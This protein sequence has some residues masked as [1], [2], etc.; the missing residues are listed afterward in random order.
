MAH[1]ISKRLR[2]M[3][4]T[5]VAL[6]AALLLVPATAFAWDGGSD[7]GT[8]TINGVQPGD[9]VHLYTI[10]T[11]ELDGQ[12]QA[13]MQAVDP[14]TQEHVNAYTAT[15]AG[16]AGAV[17]ALAGDFNADTAHE[18]TSAEVQNGQTSVSMTVDPGLYLVKVTP[19]DPDV[20]YQTTI[21]AVNV[22]GHETSWTVSDCTL[23]LKKTD[24]TLNKTVVTKNT[25]GEFTSESDNGTAKVGDTLTFRIYFTVGT[26]QSSLVLSDSMTAGL[27]FNND[28]RLYNATTGQEVASTTSVYTEG[29]APEGAIDGFTLTF[30]KDWLTA[31]SGD[32]VYTNAGAYYIEYTAD[33]TDDFTTTGAT[34]TVSN[35]Q[36]QDESN[37]S[38]NTFSVVKYAENGE[39]EGKQDDEST[40]QGAK[41]TLCSDAAGEN[42]VK[43]KYGTDI[44]FTVGPDGSWTLTNGMTNLGFG[45]YY[46]REDAAPSG[47]DAMKTPMKIEWNAD[48]QTFYVPNTASGTDS[49]IGLPTT[50]G[51]GT[52]LFTA[53]GVVIIAGAAAFIVRSRKQND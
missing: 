31:T 45:T 14:F 16:S 6:V 2:G 20:D 10:A 27:D 41:F 11:T 28:I 44:T 38:F 12:N 46:L 35:G 37:I 47:Y 8:V 32:N 22:V 53:A 51:M 17:T 5:A 34:N 7:Q 1:S 25:E 42:P 33:V 26:N 49:G 18:A 48:G 23:T 21:A 4:A 3:F 40:L 13:Y 52:V 15:P 39:E 19:E 9:T 36:N 24:D 43:D 30:L 29:D 50:G